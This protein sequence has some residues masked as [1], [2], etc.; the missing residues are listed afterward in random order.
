MCILLI[1]SLVRKVWRYQRGNRYPYIE[2]HTKQW[3]KENL[4][5]ERKRST[6][7]THKTEDRVTRT[8]LKTGGELKCSGRVNSSC[9]TSDTCRINLVTN[10]VISHERRKDR[11]VFT[12]SGTY[13]LFSISARLH[14]RHFLSILFCRIRKAVITQIFWASDL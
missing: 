9:S 4:Q 12:T 1:W 13:P 5:K 8:P 2:E 10:P 11:K 6:K 7:H 14:R 3:P